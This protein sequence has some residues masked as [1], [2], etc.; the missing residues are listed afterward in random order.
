[1]IAMS[2]FADAD[3][4]LLAELELVAEF[5]RGREG[6]EY[7]EVL[8]NIDD[9]GLAALLSKWVNVGAYRRAFSG[10]DAKMLL[11]PVLLKAIDEPS[12]YLNPQEF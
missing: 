1:M 10:Y 3:D 11:T 4:A 12:A 6:N 7:V 2:R 9:E 8:K 5:W